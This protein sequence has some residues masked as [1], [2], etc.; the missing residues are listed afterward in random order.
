MYVTM[1]GENVRLP[2]LSHSL[3]LQRV[4]TERRW[5]DED[6]PLAEAW[7]KERGISYGR[8]ALKKGSENN[9]EEVGDVWA[10]ELELAMLVELSIAVGSAKDLDFI[11]ALGQL[12]A[13]LWAKRQWG[14]TS[15]ALR[16]CLS[17][18]IFWCSLWPL[19]SSSMNR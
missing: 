6:A 10:D 14:G 11:A 3:V 7:M 4:G 19:W 18:G 9:A 17:L 1:P 8:V 16:D 15:G 5:P 13:V 12:R 2:P